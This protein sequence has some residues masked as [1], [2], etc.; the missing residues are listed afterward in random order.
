MLLEP[1]IANLPRY[2]G[3]V[4]NHAWHP[5]SRPDEFR[6]GVTLRCALIS[7]RMRSLTGEVCIKLLTNRRTTPKRVG[8]MHFIEVFGRSEPVLPALLLRPSGDVEQLHQVLSLEEKMQTTDRG[9]PSNAVQPG[10]RPGHYRTRGTGLT[11]TPPFGRSVIEGAAPPLVCRGRRTL[12]AA[13]VPNR[14]SDAEQFRRGRGRSSLEQSRRPA[15]SDSCLF[16]I[17]DARTVARRN[18]HVAGDC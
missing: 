3:S 16:E 7:R 12:T 1:P 10:P 11:Q 14:P 4:A 15:T 2:R 9:M 17:C 18:P 5:P 8:G 13:T 6:R